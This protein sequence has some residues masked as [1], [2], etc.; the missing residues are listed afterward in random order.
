MGLSDNRCT[1]M[2]KRKIT[3]LP[4]DQLVTAARGENPRVRE[5]ACTALVKLH[6]SQ[7]RAFAR[8]IL[9]DTDLAE[10]AVQEAWLEGFRNL[11]ALQEPAAFP[12]WFRRIVF[13]QCDR[14][15][16]RSGY[17]EVPGGSAEL[18]KIE[19]RKNPGQ[20]AAQDPA[21]IVADR[22]ERAELRRRLRRTYRKLSRF[23]RRLARLSFVE[24]KPYQEIAKDLN[25]TV[26]T[27]KNR[28]RILR[29]NLRP[30]LLGTDAFARQKMYAVTSPASQP[31]ATPRESVP[32]AARPRTHRNAVIDLECARALAA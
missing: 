13:K 23:D 5:Q 19:H 15:R 17:R 7:A 26:D 9:R 32:H 11:K 6:Q 12:F 1:N 2:K 4:T 14:I 21:K 10:D 27:I 22:F 18:E 28:V 3:I 31:Q 25:V 8:A 24:K 20:G 29:R 16:R 30:Q